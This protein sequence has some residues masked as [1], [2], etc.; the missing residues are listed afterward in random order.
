M[1][2]PSR[3]PR[4]QGFEVEVQSLLNGDPT[5]RAPVNFPGVL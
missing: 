2:S 4:R 1:T 5:K 3:T